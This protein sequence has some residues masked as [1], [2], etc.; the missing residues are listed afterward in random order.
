MPGNV[1]EVINGLFSVT[2]LAGFL[3]NDAKYL[4][5]YYFLLRLSSCREILDEIKLW[6]QTLFEMVLNMWVS[7]NQK[8]EECKQNPDDPTNQQN[9]QLAAQNP[10]LVGLAQR[11]MLNGYRNMASTPGDD[12]IALRE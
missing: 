4:F 3:S 10:L 9:L 2:E 6:A 5:V 1:D 8:I 12:Q 11:A 7:T